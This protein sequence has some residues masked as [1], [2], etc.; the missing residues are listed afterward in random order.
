MI[1]SG[2]PERSGSFFGAIHD[3]I[4]AVYR[5]WAYAD[6]E[7]DRNQWSMS[8]FLKGNMMLYITLLATVRAQSRH[9]MLIFFALFLYSWKI[10]DSEIISPT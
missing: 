4:K 6:N 2:S 1:N 5:T 10:G 9:R 7:Y 3:L 8:W